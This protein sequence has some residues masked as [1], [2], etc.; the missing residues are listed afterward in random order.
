MKDEF[1]AFRQKIPEDD[2]IDV[3]DDMPVQDALETMF[4]RLMD[5]IREHID[6]IRIVVLEKEVREFLQAEKMCRFMDGID[7][8]FEK[9]LQKRIETGEIGYVDTK[10]AAL[11][12]KGVLLNGVLFC[13]IGVDVSDEIS[14]EKRK[15][16]ILSFLNNRKEV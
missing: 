14:S 6:I 3:F 11:I 12:L 5:F 15:E 7:S 10:A 4:S 2:A 1:I 8:F 16:V 9:F 13:I